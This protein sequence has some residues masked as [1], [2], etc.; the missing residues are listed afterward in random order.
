MNDA[1][2]CKGIDDSYRR[3][4]SFMMGNARISKVF[5]RIIL[6]EKFM[7]ASMQESKLVQR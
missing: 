7:F 6:I 1:Y 3:E 5:N 4:T 2:G